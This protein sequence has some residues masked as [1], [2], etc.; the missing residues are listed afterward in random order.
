MSNFVRVTTVAVLLAAV[1]GCG[2][3]RGGRFVEETENSQ[4]SQRDDGKKDEGKKGEKEDAPAPALKGDARAKQ[5]QALEVIVERLKGKVWVRRGTL[6]EVYAVS[7]ADTGAP[8]S[9]LGVLRNLPHLEWLTVDSRNL[10]DSGL[11]H[12]GQC[13]QLKTLS[14][15]WAQ[16][17][18]GGLAHLT[19]LEQI[20]S[21]DLRYSSVNGTGLTLLAK[22]PR[23]KTLHLGGTGSDIKDDE[24]KYLKGLAALE[25][26]TLD[27]SN[28]A[29][30][31]KGL[32]HLEAVPG[33]RRLSLS[34]TFKDD[35]IGK[36]K[37]LE[38]LR[39]LSV[40]YCSEVTD[41]SVKHFAA[42]PALEDLSLT[43][44]RVTENGVK[45]LQKERPKLKVTR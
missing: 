43:G 25:S 4:A 35:G 44:C 45:K 9:A 29:F 34:F 32:A 41:A 24:L 10:S 23:L 6:D 14:L 11:A 18:D 22:L 7:F 38:K 27:S 8:G 19:G 16:I 5:E 17:T 15:R 21:V 28:G 36:L 26:L 31:D 33:L 40:S 2:G 39:T 37:G 3:K 42:M 1:A 13:K 20:E 30:T 12:I